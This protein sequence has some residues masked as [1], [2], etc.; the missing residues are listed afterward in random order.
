MPQLS[1]Q[2]VHSEQID[3]VF[4]QLP[5][6][7]LLEILAGTVLFNFVVL[8]TPD[9][10]PA[11]FVWLVVM[12]MAGVIRVFTERILQRDTQWQDRIRK[13]QLFLYSSAL[14]SGLL[15]GTTWVMLPL[16]VMDP[17]RGALLMWPC[18]M[19]A[20]AATNLSVKKGM[21]YCVAIPTGMLH[22]LAMSFVDNDTAIRYSI[23][24]LVFLG[25]VAILAHRS[26]KEAN[27]SIRL[28]L[29]NEAL[30][31]SLE[32]DEAKLEAQGRE[33]L[34]SIRRER[35][36]L[37]D[38]KRADRMLEMA[39]EEKLRLLDAAGEGIF[40]TNANGRL[41]FVNEMALTMLDY[42]EQEVLGQ[43]AMALLCRSSTLKGRE[44][45]TRE[46]ILRCFRE[47]ESVSSM[48]GIFAA[49]GNNV[50]PVN[51]S[52]RPIM[53]EGEFVGAVV[54]FFDISEQL[55]MESKLLRSQKMEAIGRITG[56]VA[57][58]FNNLLTVLQGNLQFL[59]KRLLRHD[60]EASITSEVELIDKMLRATKSG[61]ELNNRL[62]SYSREQA[63][64]SSEQ[65]FNAILKDMNEFVGRV[66]GEVIEFDL[67]LCEPDYVV[68]ID[69]TRF[70]N[71][72]LNICMNARDAMPD[73]GKV[74]FRSRLVELDEDP[75]RLSGL[76]AGRYVELA[77]KDTG[78]GIAPEIQ[79]KIF[80]PFFTTKTDGAG[81]GFGLSTAYGFMQ[82]SAGNIAVRSRPGEGAT[83]ILHVPVVAESRE[84]PSE[85]KVAT[86]AQK[87]YSGTVLVV[88][89]DSRIRE[90]ASMSLM[91]AGFRVIL[92]EDGVAGLNKFREHP[93]VDLVFSDIIMPGGMTGID[94]ANEV[95]KQYPHMKILLATGYTERKL[96]DSVAGNANILCISKPYDFNELPDLIESLIHRAA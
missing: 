59:R 11:A 91:D 50:V 17:P 47:H 31:R 68:N 84:T 92:A 42:R 19:L 49:N 66:L 80:D 22:V 23:G 85:T 5:V 79:E 33:L 27:R 13:R 8:S 89:D 46:A 15:W 67:D 18:G 73:G 71:V 54:S 9:Y 16:D 56:G 90:I 48:K 36:L 86:P 55:K 61:S 83:F 53:Q 74:T 88:E 70:E 76:P 52:C 41:T 35:E 81:S 6:L 43:D 4:R 38:K 44:A 28:K 37:E 96:R 32:E 3:T 20:I 24:L 69:R 94:L 39:N 77:I 30:S 64:V 51:F 26:S 2:Q 60:E 93:E 12:A 58:D 82:Q 63:L 34:S 65:N 45:E 72:I 7:L 21:F 1:A 62:L 87:T 29:S 75:Q 78:C 14:I 57:H 10:S 95:L 40:G 25:F